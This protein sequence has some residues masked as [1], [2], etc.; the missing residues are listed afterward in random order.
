MLI[1]KDFVIIET[2]LL[3]G[4]V[5]VC[6]FFVAFFINLVT[7]TFA[8]RYLISSAILTVVAFWVPNIIGH[9]LLPPV[10]WFNGEPQN[11]RTTIWDNLIYICALSAVVCFTVWQLIVRRRNCRFPI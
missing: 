1:P 11:L 9:F 10:S 7:E 6:A 8:W 4:F 2:V 5:F 3:L